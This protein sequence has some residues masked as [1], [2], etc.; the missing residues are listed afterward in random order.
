MDGWIK[1]HRKIMDNKMWSCEPFS[2]SQAWIDLL[3]LANRQSGYFYV[4]GNKV[5]VE[6]GQVGWSALSLAKR[7]KW[8]RGKVTRFLN[9]LEME[10]QIVQQKNFVT[11]II[12]IVNY[13]Q[14]QL[15][16]TADKTAGDT[17]DGQQTDTNKKYS[18]ENI[19][20]FNTFYKKI[21]N[22]FPVKFHPQNKTQQNNWIDCLD[23]LNRIDGYDL[24]TIYRI[25][26][27][28]REDD[29]WSQ[30]FHSILK[31]RKTNKEG[32]VYHL[33]FSEKMKAASPRG[34]AEPVHR[35]RLGE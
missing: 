26:K 34:G 7:W 24:N 17:A 9:E 25:T 27:W 16:G 14:Y 33:I 11:T 30:N 21:L 8:S 28:A 15:H 2:R 20:E 32:I 23:K 13:G 4:R 19:E 1:L 22:L 5:M 18:I 3:L 31:L 10:Q 35:K 6:T 29:F 12:S